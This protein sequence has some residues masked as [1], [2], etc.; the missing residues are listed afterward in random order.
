MTMW[1]K[2]DMIRDRH[3]FPAGI[4][5]APDWRFLVGFYNTSTGE[6]LPA[7]QAGQP[8]PGDAFE[9]P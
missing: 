1:R 2:G 5:P 3:T 7:T 6:R 9:I 4:A 8:L